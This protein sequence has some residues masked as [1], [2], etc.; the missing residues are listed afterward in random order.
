MKIGVLNGSIGFASRGQGYQPRFW[1]SD[2]F[3]SMA[4]LG[5]GVVDAWYETTLGLSWSI[6]IFVGCSGSRFLWDV[7]DI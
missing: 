7:V 3:C 4:I 2:V 6:Q 5:D 1:R